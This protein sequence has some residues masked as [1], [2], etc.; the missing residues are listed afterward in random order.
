MSAHYHTDVC[1]LADEFIPDIVSVIICGII[2]GLRRTVSLT[3]L[4]Q[5]AVL[6]HISVCGDYNSVVRM[7]GNHFVCPGKNVVLCSEIKAKDHII[8]VTYLKRV[9]NVFYSSRLIVSAYVIRISRVRGK[10]GIE[11]L[12]SVVS[13]ASYKAVRQYSVHHRNGFLCRSP[14]LVSSFLIIVLMTRINSVFGYVSESDNVLNVLFGLV[15]DYPLI[16]ILK[17]SGVVVGYG[18]GV[19]DNCK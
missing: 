7:S 14:L 8:H 12:N 11:E 19:T 1:M 15:I 10:V 6:F 18:L 9:V 2:I 5:G 16:K 4:K 13:C 17:L 3:R